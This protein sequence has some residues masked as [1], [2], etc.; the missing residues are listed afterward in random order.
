MLRIPT[1]W[2]CVIASYAVLFL[3][4]WMARIGRRNE[5][6]L[7]ILATLYASGDVNGTWTYHRN[8]FLGHV[9][10]AT[11]IGLAWS[12]WLHRNSKN[13]KTPEKWSIG[14]LMSYTTLVAIFLAILSAY[15][16]P[17]TLFLIVSF[18]VFVYPC[19]RFAM[20]MICHGLEETD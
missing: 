20:P 14:G 9:F 1:Y 19:Y 6:S 16:A 7:T 17:V 12:I 2:F 18:P 10:V 15:K 8:I 3:A 13:H 4:P 5:N 11:S